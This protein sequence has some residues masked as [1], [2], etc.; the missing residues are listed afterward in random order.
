MPPMNDEIETIKAIEAA[1]AFEAARAEDSKKKV[2]VKPAS[3]APDFF[4]P[5]KD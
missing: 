1:K 2:K 4:D 3:E 5:N